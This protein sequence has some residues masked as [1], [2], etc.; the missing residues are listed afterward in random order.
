LR[1]IGS[2]LIACFI[3]AIP[4]DIVEKIRAS[5]QESKPDLIAL[6]TLARVARI[7]EFNDYVQMTQPLDPF[8]Q[9]ARE[10]G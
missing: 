2:D 10:T 6:A 8:L 9:E 3:G 5:I 4:Q 1:I 7:K